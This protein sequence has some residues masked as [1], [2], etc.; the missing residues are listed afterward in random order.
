MA[1][2]DCRPLMKRKAIFVATGLAFA[3][4]PA[5]SRVFELSP[6][7][8]PPD[9]GPIILQDVAVPPP[10]CEPR[11]GT[12]LYC[13]DFDS[14]VVPTLPDLGTAKEKDGKVEVVS[15]I[16]L[17]PPRGLV[18]NVSGSSASAAVV[19]SLQS[20]PNGVTLSADMLIATWTTDGAQMLQ[21]ELADGPS[22]CNVRL[23][24]GATTWSVLQVCSRD[25]IESARTLTAT[26]APIVKSR[27]QRFGLSV[28]FQP[29]SSV[30]LTIDDVEAMR[31]RALPDVHA[32]QTSIAYGVDLAEAGGAVVFTDNVLVTTP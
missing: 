15:A 8:P 18:S 6:A 1:V 31:E 32:A 3:A 13:Q 12:A 4:M 22:L 27:W 10:F 30:S 16:S 21:I 11:L 7:D 14:N 28:G 29:R 5:C 25:G 24:G 20:S 17:S 23:I 19:R 26:T 2:L 9:G